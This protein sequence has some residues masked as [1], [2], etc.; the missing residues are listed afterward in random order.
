MAQLKAPEI[1]ILI[2]HAAFNRAAIFIRFFE[3]IT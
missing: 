3:V 1:F 2:I